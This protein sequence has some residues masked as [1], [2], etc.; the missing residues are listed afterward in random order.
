MKKFI[1][2]KYQCSSCNEGFFI[3]DIGDF[4]YGIFIL[5]SLEGEYRYVN[6]LEDRA[7]NEMVEIIAQQPTRYQID[8][9]RVFGILTCDLSA[10]GMHF[11]ITSRCCPNCLS[12]NIFVLENNSNLKTQLKSVTHFEW[13]KLNKIQKKKST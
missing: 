4:S 5:S 8:P 12:K 2:I 11:S 6:A 3:P 9:Q 10:A 13:N 1:N 7:Y